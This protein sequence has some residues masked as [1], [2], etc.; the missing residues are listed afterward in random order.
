MTNSQQQ[1]NVPLPP[2][3][4]TRSGRQSD[5]LAREQSWLWV[6]AIIAVFAFFAWMT[7]AHWGDVRIDCGREMYVPQEL[8]RGRMLYRDLWYPYG[9]VAPYW[10]ALLFR[11]FSPSLYV[12]YASGLSITLAFALML[13]VISKCFV[14]PF[15]AFVTSF[16]F[17]VQAFHSDLFNYIL[18]YSYGATLGSLFGLLFL[19]FL[20]RDIRTAPGPNLLIAGLWSGLT[21]LTKS[22]YGVACYVTLIF[23][24]VCRLW[25]HR[26]WRALLAHLKTV[27]T[28][29]IFPIAG[30]GWFIWKLSLDFFIKDSFSREFYV[31][32]S[33]QQGLRFVPSEVL[34]LILG[35]AVALILWLGLL[36]LL[37]HLDL[38]S[39]QRPLLWL[40]L[41]CGLI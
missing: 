40:G 35:M 41:V 25:V 15:V 23:Y 22:E 31:Q 29:L 14:I 34:G 18:P 6:G 32:W 8:A 21:L 3:E 26:S 11:I 36:W 39:W 33:H 10:N 37:R 20:L 13:F 16:C 28:G 19:Y 7:W 4:D 5:W 24:L 17:L 27:A 9:P 38:S 1:F 30:Y 12:L 2:V